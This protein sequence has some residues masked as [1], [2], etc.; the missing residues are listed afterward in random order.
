MVF[1]WGGGFHVGLVINMSSI[2]RWEFG[3]VDYTWSA[4]L[5][6]LGVHNII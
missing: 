1:F 3:D 5:F 2:S 4:L 6:L